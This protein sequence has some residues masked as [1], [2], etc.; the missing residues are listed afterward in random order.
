[1]E[2]PMS[3]FG[4]GPTP[5]WDYTGVL[6]KVGFGDVLKFAV[7][8]KEPVERSLINV[9]IWSGGASGFVLKPLWPSKR[10]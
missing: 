7:Y 4:Q 9:A 5:L 1:M 2:L 8:R 3:P 10:T 6:S